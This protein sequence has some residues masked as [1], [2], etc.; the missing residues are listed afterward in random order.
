MNSSMFL[1][2]AELIL[3]IYKLYFYSVAWIAI[4]F[5]PRKKFFS[6]NSSLIN[7]LYRQGKV[8]FWTS[9]PG[10][11]RYHSATQTPSIFLLA[12]FRPFTGDD[13]LQY[14]FASASRIGAI[15]NRIG[16]L[17]SDTSSL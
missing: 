9:T 8:F 4:C 1:V 15:A 12:R 3:M 14:G 10:Q 17:G 11:R 2:P 7:H 5:C 6:N 13:F 16:L